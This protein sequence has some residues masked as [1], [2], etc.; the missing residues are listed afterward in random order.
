MEREG[1]QLGELEEL[2]LLAVLRL[3]GEA[4]GARIREELQAEAGRSASIGT[5]YVT[6][7]RSE[8][9]GLIRS[10]MGEPSSVRGGKAKRFFA[11]LPAGM[12]SLERARQIREHMWKGV[13][14]PRRTHAR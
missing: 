7:M 6:L 1:V 10:W 11:L 8:E 9:K 3:G 4:Y 14:A 5:I 12:A 2:V 13:A